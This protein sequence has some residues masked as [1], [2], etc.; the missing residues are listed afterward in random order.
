LPAHVD[1]TLPDQHDEKQLDVELLLD[2]VVASQILTLRDSN[3]SIFDTIV[4]IAAGLLA[5]EV[6]AGFRDPPTKGSQAKALTIF[7]DTPLVLRLLDL[8]LE[9]EYELVRDL[10]DDVRRMGASIAVFDHTVEETRN[11]ISAAL[12]VPNQISA[13]GNVARRVLRD[14]NARTRARAALQNIDKRLR[15]EGVNTVYF[16]RVHG[17]KYKYFPKNLEEDLITYIR[18]ERK[19]QPREMDAKS[20]A[21]TF[22]II[23]AERPVHSVVA[24]RAAF[25]S[26]NIGL[27]IAGLKYFNGFNH[28]SDGQAPPF[29]SDEQLAGLVWVAMGGAADVIPKERVIAAC[30]AAIAPRRDV[31]TKMVRLLR[32]L[33]KEAADEYEVLVTEERCLHYL[34]DQSLGSPVL[35][36]ADN[37]LETLSRIRQGVAADV[38]EAKERE[39]GEALETQKSRMMEEFQGEKNQ[40]EEALGD[41]HRTLKTLTDEVYDMR[42]RLEEPNR[43]RDILDRHLE[44]AQQGTRTAT[45]LLISAN[46]LAS[47]RRTGVMWTVAIYISIALVGV[48]SLNALE[49]F[50]GTEIYG[51]AVNPWISSIMWF[52]VT[53]HV[54]LLQFHLIP[55]YLFGGLKK[56]KKIKAFNRKAKELG[57]EKEA[58]SVHVDWDKCTIVGNMSAPTTG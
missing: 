32:N 30:M 11:V 27:V 40:L 38:A 45:A 36:T 47:A 7:L 15:E 52:L 23:A 41:A 22:R 16:D 14:A 9:Q 17:D 20:L 8:S 58:Q 39:K 57:I 2:F 37:A 28:L 53:L 21:N 25:V 4:D 5:S 43:N 51:I 24:A 33:D 13:V 49:P 34:M 54:G 19:V 35:I 46:C 26:S 42:D 56:K 12:H 6:I 50:Q 18:P 44:S 55:D 10:T 48:I 3:P 1:G 31:I 29:L